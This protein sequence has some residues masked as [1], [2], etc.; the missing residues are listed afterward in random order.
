MADYVL[1]HHGIKGQKWGRRRYQN[2]D[3]SLTPEGKAR[4][5]VELG[6]ALKDKQW[7]S[8][9]YDRNAQLTDKEKKNLLDPEKWKR[10]DDW[11]SQKNSG[12]YNAEAEGANLIQSRAMDRYEKA[13]K[14]GRQAAADLIE[15]STQ[16][17][18]ER[19]WQKVYTNRY[20][21]EEEEKK[22]YEESQKKADNWLKNAW[23]TSI[24][25]I[26]DFFNSIFNPKR[27]EPE[28]KSNWGR[29]G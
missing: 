25:S 15:S 4:Y 11:D 24:N 21:D 26:G 27:G 19:Y 9:Q 16:E 28:V 12:R 20:L 13:V 6:K 29:M 23:D 18:L 5:N 10:E 2:K 1:T 7:K 14:E 22:K 17:E 8:G 3:G